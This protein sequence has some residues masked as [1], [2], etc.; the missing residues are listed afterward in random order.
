M[1]GVKASVPIQIW[2]PA[3][4]EGVIREQF[5]I[6]FMGSGRTHRGLAASVVALSN[7]L[8]QFEAQLRPD[9]CGGHR[10]PLTYGDV[11]AIKATVEQSRQ[12]QDLNSPETRIHAIRLLD[13]DEMTFEALLPRSWVTPAQYPTLILLLQSLN[14]VS[15]RHVRRFLID[16]LL[17]TNTALG[18]LTVPASI[19][20]HHA[21]PGG[22]LEHTVDM[23]LE[24]EQQHRNGLDRLHMDVMRALIIV[25]DIGKVVTHV[26]GAYTQRG[27]WQPHE[28]AGLELLA[29]PLA[30]LERNVPSMAN[31]IRAAFK[32]PNYHPK[33]RH[34]L[35]TLLSDLDR[36]SANRKPID[37]RS[38][39]VGDRELAD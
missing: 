32:P 8:Y 14:A 25:H 33:Q 21:Y 29:S 13:P 20:H 35:H 19:R 30:T 31:I 12:S 7:S 6:V 22:L 17:N 26:S 23:L 18:L 5:R 15:H 27:Q 1:T 39:K 38:F 10:Y 9:Q 37:V 16:V 11:V 24:L 3:N 36:T 2:P 34:E 4:S 28:P